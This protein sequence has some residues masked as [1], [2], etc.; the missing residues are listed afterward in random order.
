MR[1]NKVLLQEMKKDMEW[2]SRW[3]HYDL[4][5]TK[6]VAS[7]DARIL[8]SS[9]LSAFNFKNGNSKPFEVMI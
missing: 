9:N 2:P 7:S 8:D 1:K 5:M 4:A 6:E 3:N